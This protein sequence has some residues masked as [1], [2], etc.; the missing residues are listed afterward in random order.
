MAGPKPIEEGWGRAAKPVEGRG[1]DG[2]FAEQAPRPS[3]G[4]GVQ[5]GT[6]P[7]REGTD[8]VEATFMIRGGVSRH[9]RYRGRPSQRLSRI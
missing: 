3:S 1:R 2:E 4:F 6:R 5:A 7:A 9:V 8:T